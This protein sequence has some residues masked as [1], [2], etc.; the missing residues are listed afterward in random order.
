MTNPTG[1]KDPRITGRENGLTNGARAGIFLIRTGPLAGLPDIVWCDVP[2]GKFVYA[3]NSSPEIA[4]P[5][6]IA[7][8]PV[9]NSQFLS[10]IQDPSGYANAKWWAGLND[11]AGVQQLAGPADAMWPD[12]DRPREMVSWYEAMA[13]CEWLSH[14]LGYKVSLPTEEQWEKAA[15]GPAGS[16]YPYGSRF[17][18][19]KS[20]TS[21]S[22]FGHTTAV[23][24]YRDGV[25]PYGAL[26]MS[27]NV[28]EWTLSEYHSRRNDNLSS[29]NPRVLRGGSWANSRHYAK[30]ASRICNYPGD[31][32]VNAGFRLMSPASNP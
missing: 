8:Y 12:A 6:R 32:F 4:E 7:K 15:R 27:G 26:G 2:A 24:L 1:D 23:D 5:Y 22:R 31:R 14:R 28:W 18:D 30:A 29:D 20:N 16:T 25:S 11:A 21:E 13:F 17:D 19:Y 3:D 10:F 9:T